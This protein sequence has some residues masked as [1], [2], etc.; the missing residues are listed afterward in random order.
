MKWKSPRNGGNSNRTRMAQ[1]GQSRDRDGHGRFG[2]SGHHSWKKGKSGGNKIGAS[3][4]PLGGWSASDRKYEEHHSFAAKQ[5]E[6]D[7]IQEGLAEVWEED[8][9][10]P[11]RFTPEYV[12]DQIMES[13]YDG[14]LAPGIMLNGE[15]FDSVLPN[16]DEQYE[17]HMSC[18]CCGRPF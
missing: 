2:F 5:A 11:Y 3:T 13:L 16:Y 10:G 17:S 12:S 14:D 4:M 9:G 15:P 6:L 18:Q 7:V 1:S 8:W